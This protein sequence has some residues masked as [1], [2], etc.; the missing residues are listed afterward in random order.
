MDKLYLISLKMLKDKY[1][2]DEYSRDK[3]NIIYYQVFGNNKNLEI[4]DLNKL[5]F[6]L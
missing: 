1:N 2:L 5:W 6:A 4:N 3:F